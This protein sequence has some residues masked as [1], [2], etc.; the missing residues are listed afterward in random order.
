MFVENSTSGRTV[1][2]CVDDLPAG[3]YIVYVYDVENGIPLTSIS[4]AIILRNVTVYIQSTTISEL[5]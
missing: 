4:P 1:K 5:I 3:N 2:G